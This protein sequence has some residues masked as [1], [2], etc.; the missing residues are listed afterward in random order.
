MKSIL[1]IT[2]RVI[3][4]LYFFIPGI[5]KFFF[6]SSHVQLMETHNMPMVPQLLA[7]AGTTQMLAGI[8]LFFGRYT[9]TACIFLGIL[10]V[11][12]NFNLHD[13]WNDYEGINSTHEAQNFIK[14]LGILAGLSLLASIS[15]NNTGSKEFPE[16]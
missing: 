11:L 6:W 5:L 13:F 10:V 7:L 1:F 4:S 16:K 12:I 14:N 2:G 3:I 15:I 8:A 9:V